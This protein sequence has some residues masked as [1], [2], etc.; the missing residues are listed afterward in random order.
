MSIMKLSIE[1]PADR[2][3]DPTG[4]Q[5]QVPHGRYPI[6]YFNKSMSY[7]CLELRDILV[8]MVFVTN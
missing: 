2:F 8:F 3:K 4:G 1:N 5:A 7:E 6:L